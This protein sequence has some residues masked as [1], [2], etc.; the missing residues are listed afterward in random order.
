MLDVSIQ[1]TIINHT[2]I[3]YDRFDLNQMTQP[4][5]LPLTACDENAT[6]NWSDKHQGR[7]SGITCAGLSTMFTKVLRTVQIRQ[8]TV[9]TPA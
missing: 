2:D 7:K 9:G 6:E 4:T 3:T 5:I 1:A 8:A